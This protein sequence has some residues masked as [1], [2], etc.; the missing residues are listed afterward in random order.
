MSA[1][2][3]ASH[4]TELLDWIRKYNLLFYGSGAQHRFSLSWT[5][6]PQIAPQ[7]KPLFLSSVCGPWLTFI[8]D[9]LWLDP[10]CRFG[11]Q[12]HTMGRTAEIPCRDAESTLEHLHSS[13]TAERQGKQRMV[14]TARQSLLCAHGAALSLSF[15]GQ[16]ARNERQM[17]FMEFRAEFEASLIGT[18][19]FLPSIAILG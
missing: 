18:V 14:T 19:L 1:P 15:V 2:F 11:V 8:S 10:R 6:E 12:R 7:G 4:S 17:K 9:A 16:A 13:R 5:I 3:P